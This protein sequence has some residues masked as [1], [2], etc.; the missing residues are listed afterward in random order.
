[1][2]ILFILLGISWL[3]VTSRKNNSTEEPL[4]NQIFVSKYCS[5]Q[6]KKKHAVF[7]IMV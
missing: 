2:R 6:D 4:I 1:M 5:K 7:G 3:P